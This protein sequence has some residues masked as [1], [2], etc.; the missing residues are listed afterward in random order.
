MAGELDVIAFG[1]EVC[2]DFGQGVTRE[3]LETNGL[4]GYASSTIVG[5]NT[6]RYHGLLVAALAPPGR[7]TML[8]SKLEETLAVRDVE[9]DLSCNQYPGAVHPQVRTYYG[10]ALAAF[11]VETTAGI[12]FEDYLEEYIFKPL[13]MHQST[14]RQP[15]PPELANNMSVGYTYEN[16]VFKAEEFELLNGIAPAGSMSTTAT[17]ISKF[18]IA[19]LQ[20]GKYGEVKILEEETAE[21]MHTRLFSH[22]PHLNGNAHGFWE[23]NL[24]N[25]RILE[26]GGDTVFFHTFFVMIPEKNTGFFVSYNSIGAGLNVREELLQAFLDRYY[27]TGEAAKP[28]P[29][30]DFKERISRITGYY[31]TT[32]NVYTTFDADYKLTKSGMK[33]NLFKYCYRVIRWAKFVY[34][35]IIRHDPRW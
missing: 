7:R 32:R 6:R 31:G 34:H 11:I 2:R 30:S 19:H 21:L 26:H 35:G 22:D 3:W 1:P 29:S 16:G 25:L 33:R 23:R 13:D 4:G 14:F 18:M 10:S 28:I 12:P 15:L 8:L 17:D 24:N 20:N 5:A 27:P 9:Y